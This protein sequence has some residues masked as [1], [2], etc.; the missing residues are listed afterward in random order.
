MIALSLPEMVILRKVVKTRLVV[1]SIA[2]I[3]TRI[4][5]VGCIFNALLNVGKS[6]SAGRGGPGKLLV[7]TLPG[8]H[9]G[10]ILEW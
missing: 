2:V 9:R 8:C 10:T 5:L 4:L 6:P 1:T 7:T 3:A